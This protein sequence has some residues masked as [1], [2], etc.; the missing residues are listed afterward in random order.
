MRAQVNEDKIVALVSTGNVEIGNIPL[1][2]AKVG[3]ERLRWD[4]SN[5][6]DLADLEEIWVR[7]LSPGFELHVIQVSN[8]QLVSMYYKDRKNLAIKDNIVR[9]LTV[10]EIEQNE[11]IAQGLMRNNKRLSLIKL[12]MLTIIQLLYVVIVYVRTNNSVLGEFLDDLIPD[13]QDT[14]KFSEVKDDISQNIKKL[15]DLM[16]DT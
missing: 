14:F 7:P 10:Q 1:D 11:R 15:K 16:D 6:I 4:G 12:F 2:K 9:V 8:S 3:L 5:I 13:I